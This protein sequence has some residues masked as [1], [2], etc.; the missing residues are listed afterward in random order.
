MDG[1]GTYCPIFDTESGFDSTATPS[2]FTLYCVAV[3]GEN[4][5]LRATEGV[6]EV[7]ARLHWIIWIV[8]GQ[9]SQQKE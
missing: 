8:A 6:N 3:L 9:Y 1:H 5:P 2:F 4:P 7:V